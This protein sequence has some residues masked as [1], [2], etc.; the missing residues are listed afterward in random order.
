MYLVR[1]PII[2]E[3]CRVVYKQLRATNV[4]QR[5][6]MQL[7]ST[8][9]HAGSNEFFR[10]L[11]LEPLLL[12]PPKKTQKIKQNKQNKKQNKTQRNENHNQTLSYD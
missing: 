4:P 3:V 2:T 10:N 7:Y 6:Q 1:N 8:K 9:V 11:N 12:H 5:S